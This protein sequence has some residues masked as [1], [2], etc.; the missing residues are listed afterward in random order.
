VDEGSVRAGFDDRSVLD[1][2]D[3]VDFG[4]EMK[5]VGDEDDSLS[6]SSKVVNDSVL[7]DAL[8]DWWDE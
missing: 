7:E 4:E 8:P 5:G 3:L 1:S 6:S 2:K